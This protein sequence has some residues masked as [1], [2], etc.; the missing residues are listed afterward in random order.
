MSVLFTWSIKP[1]KRFAAL[2]LTICLSLSCLSSAFADADWEKEADKFFA[3]MENGQPLPL[4]KD[5]PGEE[6]SI[7]NAYKVQKILFEKLLSKGEA[8]AGFKGA[9]TAPAQMQRFGADRPASAPLFRSGL[10]EADS[11]GQAELHSFRGMMLEAELAFKTALP[12]TAPVEDEESLKKLIAGVHPAIEIPQVYF[13]DMSEVGVFDIVAAGI[14]SRQF[15]I[16][17][18]FPVDGV[19]LDRIKVKLDLDGATVNEG[20]ATDA[21]GGQWKA[22]LWLVNNTLSQGYTIEAGQYLMT[23]ALGNMIPAR[24]GTYTADY[25]FASLTFKVLE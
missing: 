22:L 11:S 17:P 23:G 2:F 15:L 6:R 21:L 9:L 25:S 4:L 12:I 7:D 18:F 8:I 19:D 20:A 24:P 13:T 5:V 1:H 14:G 16:G 3:A 10:I